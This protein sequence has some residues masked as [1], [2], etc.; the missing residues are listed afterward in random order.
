MDNEN[1]SEHTT[2][3]E[4]YVIMFGFFKKKADRHAATP[5]KTEENAHTAPGTQIHYS[6]D[7]IASLQSDH[8]NLLALYGEINNAFTEKRYADVS[9]MLT[10]FRGNLNAHLLTENVRLY[11]YLDHSLAN[12]ASSHDLI[13]G[14]RKEMDDIAKVALGFLRKYEAIGVDDDLAAHFATDFATIGKVLVERIQKEEKT[15][16]PLYMPSY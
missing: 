4:V 9:S 10:T 2:Y 7:L 13:H 12:D 14:F 6:P 5:T 8:Q 3:R 11:I 15:L 16:Y 1:P